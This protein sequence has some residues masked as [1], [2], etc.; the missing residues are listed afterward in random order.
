MGGLLESRRVQAG[1]T[2]IPIGHWKK[3]VY[4]IRDGV[5]RPV[6]VINF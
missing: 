5:H 6:S 2:S 1:D 4:F 3:G